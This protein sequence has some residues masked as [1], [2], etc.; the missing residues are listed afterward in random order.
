MAEPKMRLA[1]VGSRDFQE[2]WMVDDYLNQHHN[3]IESI[4]S[5]GARGVDRRAEG[6]GMRNS[7]SVVSFRPH[8]LVQ[9]RNHWCVQRH[10]LTGVDSEFTTL[11]TRYRNFAGAAFVR[12]TFIVE[13][14][15]D[16]V[17]FWDGHSIGTQDSIRKARELGNLKDIING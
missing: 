7:I 14:A 1:V 12:N 11:P 3:D 16:V 8:R 5:G 2:L 4:V 17:A 6:W 10:I 9:D 13:F 15:T